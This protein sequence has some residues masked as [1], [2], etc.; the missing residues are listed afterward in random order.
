[1]VF[2]KYAD[3]I[4]TPQA[5]SIG[6]VAIILCGEQNGPA[7][8]ARYDLDSMGRGNAVPTSLVGLIGSRL[9]TAAVPTWEF[10][11]GAVKLPR[12][13]SLTLKVASPSTPIVTWIVTQLGYL[14]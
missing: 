9:T 10:S 14:R 2:P 7:T 4:E 3:F 13:F 6:V 8:P 11:P 5:A 12:P 1:V